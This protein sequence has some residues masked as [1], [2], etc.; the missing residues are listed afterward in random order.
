VPRKPRKLLGRFMVADPAD[1]HGK[2]T[3]LGTRI[4]G[5]QMLKQV[6]QGMPWDA[7]LASGPAAFGTTP[8]PK[9]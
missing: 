3:F 9:R 5:A 8:S 4:M 2:P 6:A 7:I 1:C